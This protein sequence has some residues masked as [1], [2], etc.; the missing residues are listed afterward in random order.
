MVGDGV[1]D[2]PALV[3][4]D[5][6]IAM[7]GGTDIAIEAGDI[8]LM[9]EDLRGVVAA[10]QLGERIMKQVIENLAWAFVYNLALIPLAVAG[11]LYPIYAGMAMAFSSISVSSW[12]LLLKRYKPEIVRK[13]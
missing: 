6:G 4:A 3:Q 11:Y 8:I 9:R 10:I 7:G 2:A 1:N 13:R 5:I 12:S